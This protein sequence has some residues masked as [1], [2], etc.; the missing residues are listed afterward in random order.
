[1]TGRSERDSIRLGNRHRLQQFFHF[2][3]AA[4]FLNEDKEFIEAVKSPMAL[5]ALV[6]ALNYS[7]ARVA[8]HRV[9]LLRSSV[10]FFLLAGNADIA[11]DTEIKKE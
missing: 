8:E 5:T 9:P 10:G 1:M 2:P 3:Q 7:V 4:D 6:T 11:S